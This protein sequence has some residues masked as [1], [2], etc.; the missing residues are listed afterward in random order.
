[1][2]VVAEFVGG[3]VELEAYEAKGG[4]GGHWRSSQG[5]AG[6]RVT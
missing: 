5:T 2:A 6:S 3:D 1:L 4:I